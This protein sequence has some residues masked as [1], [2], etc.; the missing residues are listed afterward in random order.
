MPTIL[1][2]EITV[3]EGVEFRL[4]DNTVEISGKKG[5]LKK[6]FAFQGVNLKSD[7]RKIIIEADSKKRKSKAAIGTV[8]AH[9]KNMF[10][11]VTEGFVYKMRVVY[12]HFPITVKVEGKK[13]LINNFIGER[14]PRSAKIVGGAE[15]EVN[16]DQVIVRGIDKEDVGQT[17]INIERATAVRYLDRRVFQDG[18]FLTETG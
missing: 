4:D 13:V 16:G 6:E 9:L 5:K 12:S 8:L 3:P 11:G 2:E 17:A 14:F 18:C 7:G 1:K 10:K 15:V